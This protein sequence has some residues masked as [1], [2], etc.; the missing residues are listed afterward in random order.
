MVETYHNILT[1]VMKKYIAIMLVIAAVIALIFI[2]HKNYI[3]L[4]STVSIR[5]T[6]WQK[7]HIQVRKGYKPNPLN[8]KL[9]F[10]Q[11]LTMGQ[12]RTFT[13]DNND[14]IVYRRDMDP[15]HPDGVHFTSWTYANCDDSS[16]CTVDN[17]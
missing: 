10:D 7:V 5:N 1:L 17:P 15:N 11:S 16:V 6:R 3:H 12:S 13:I 2:L 9:I 8:D 14:E 4:N